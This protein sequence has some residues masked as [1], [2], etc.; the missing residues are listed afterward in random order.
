MKKWVNNTALFVLLFAF[1][2]I[3]AGCGE[4]DLDGDSFETRLRGTWETHNPQPYDYSG[5]IVIGKTTITITGYEKMFYDPEDDLQC[6]FKDITKGVSLK[7]YSKVDSS[8]A[9]KG[10]IYINDFDWKEGI[11]YE[12]M[13]TSTSSGTYPDYTKLLRFSFE[14]RSET[15]RKIKE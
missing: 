4:S 10:K 6:P 15:L 2:L 7:G 3:P 9:G 5:M 13:S 11:T 12:Y 14:G 1:A 8:A